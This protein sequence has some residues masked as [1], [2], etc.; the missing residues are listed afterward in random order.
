LRGKWRGVIVGEED[1]QESGCSKAQE[2]TL[3]KLRNGGKLRKDVKRTTS[4][5]TKSLYKDVVD[6]ETKTASD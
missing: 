6:D 5:V 3:G 4:S 2:D 1:N